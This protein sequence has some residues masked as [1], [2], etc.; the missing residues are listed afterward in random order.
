[1]VDATWTFTVIFIAIGA[2]LAAFA[3]LWLKSEHSGSES[4]HRHGK[5]PRTH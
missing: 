5:T 3:I 1:M 2:A 4:S